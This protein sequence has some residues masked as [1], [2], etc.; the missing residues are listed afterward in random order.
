MEWSSPPVRH[1]IQA[2]FLLSISYSLTRS[3]NTA[4]FSRLME[5]GKASGVR[6]VAVNRRDYPGSTPFSDEDKRVL[7]SGT[8]AERA[9]FLREQGVEIATFVDRLIEKNGLPPLSADKKSG[10]VQL[11]GWSFGATLAM[12]ALANL[13]A[14]PEASQTRLAAHLRSLILFGTFRLAPQP[15]PLALGSHTYV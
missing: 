1:P 10:G 11:M 14:L 3:H 7:N 15:P 13:D 6:V 8:D 5:R 2:Y 4:V 12:A 9:A